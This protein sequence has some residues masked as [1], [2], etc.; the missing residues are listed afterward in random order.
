MKLATVA[1]T[2]TAALCLPAW[3]QENG[4]F[5]VGFRA[6]VGQYGYVDDPSH[7]RGVFGVE[8]CAFCNG[9]F[10]LFTGYSRFL[11]PGEP[12]GYQSGD[13]VGVGLRIQGRRQVRPF[14]DVGLAVG[15]SRFGRGAGTRTMTTAGLELGG[16]VT[17][18]AGSHLYF[19]PQVR[20]RVMN[21]LYAAL[22][23]EMG[24]GW[25]F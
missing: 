2:M 25:R 23:A 15:G 13:L 3:A 12:S 1:L 4:R 5:E 11:A 9:G 21:E 14:F 18:L 8:A 6:G 22:S 17:I 10:A 16:G 7:K 20:L 19:R 24:I